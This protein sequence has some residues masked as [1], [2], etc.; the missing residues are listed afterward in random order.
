MTTL[1]YELSVAPAEALERLRPL[2]TLD[3]DTHVEDETFDAAGRLTS[4]TLQWVKAGN[5]KMKAWDNTILGRLRL[6]GS[7]LVVDVNSARRRDRI[8]RE[9]TKRLGSAAALVDTTVT[10]IAAELQKRRK[11]AGGLAAAA[12]SEDAARER[13]AELAAIEAEVAR[14]QWDA[15]VD[16]KVPALGNRTPRQ[17]A[18][19]ARGRERLEALLSDF[20]RLAERSPSPA[21]PDIA[22]LRKTLGLE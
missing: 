17:A 3:G 21:V 19:S 4:A 20:G 16:T 10:D 9:V 6:E 8:A 18:K 13:P 11:G 5:R 7:R 15:W 2:A 14:Q 1:T 22:T 12:E